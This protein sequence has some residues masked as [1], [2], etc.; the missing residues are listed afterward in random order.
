VENKLIT[1]ST[2]IENFKKFIKNIKDL[3]TIDPTIIIVF[4]KSYILMY[5]FVGKNL[6]NIHSFKSIVSTPDNIFSN[7]KEI[8]SNIT[9]IIK[10]GKRFLKNIINFVDYDEELKFKI[11]FDTSDYIINYIQ[12]FNSKLKMKEISGDPILISKNITLD[13]INQLTN[14]DNSLLEFE[15]SNEELK[16]I[17]KLSMIDLNNDILELRIHNNEIFIG[18]TK[19]ELLINKKEYKNLNVSFPKRY[20]NTLSSTSDDINKFYLFENYILIS[21]NNSN[22]MIILEMTI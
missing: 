21:N 1:Y 9:L 5:S 18:E 14:I 19:W 6:N 12:I 16:R 10:D 13:D 11:S 7:Y 15:I 4:N 20:F 3:S 17:K 8:D 2:N 22:L